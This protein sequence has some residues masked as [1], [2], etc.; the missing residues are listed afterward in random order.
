ML[1]SMLLKIGGWFLEKI[2]GLLFDW[3]KAKIGAPSAVQTELD[4]LKFSF[5]TTMIVNDLHKPLAEFRSFFGRHPALLHIP[6]NRLF[7]ERWLK[8]PILQAFGGAAGVWSAESFAQV[9]GDV[10]ALRV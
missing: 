9:R 1:S 8:N 2:G 5:L 3:G 6:E 4:S 7:C 10:T